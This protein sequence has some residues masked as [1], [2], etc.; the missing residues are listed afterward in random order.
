MAKNGHFY[1]GGKIGRSNANLIRLFSVASY[2]LKS[3]IINFE[4]SKRSYIMPVGKFTFCCCSVHLLQRSLVY[5]FI[6]ILQLVTENQPNIYVVLLLRLHPDI[7]TCTINILA[8]HIHNEFAI[9]HFMFD[10][11][12]HFT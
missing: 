9:L 10:N 12:C 3:I 5:S 7:N 4:M 6:I 11:S 2:D 1:E 8:F